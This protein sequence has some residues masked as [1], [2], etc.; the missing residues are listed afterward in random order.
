[1]APPVLAEAEVLPAPC[2][3]HDDRLR[4]LETEQASHAAQLR[5]GNQMFE[6]IQESIRSLSGHVSD[7]MT[8]V[9][10]TVDRLAGE[11][12]TLNSQVADVRV[13]QAAHDT[14]LSSLTAQKKREDEEA[15]DKRKTLREYGGRVAWVF[16]FFTL[17]A[18]AGRYGP[19]WL[20]DLFKLMAG[21]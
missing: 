20:V 18:L 13:K 6:N 5:A 12:S 19:G 2:S 10:R 14:T 8:R 4:E 11:V 1:M 16:L 9:E 7:S 17:S 15:A 21:G 3:I